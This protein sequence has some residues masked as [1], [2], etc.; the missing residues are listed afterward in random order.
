MA[1]GIPAALADS[2]ALP[3]V[4]GEAGWYFAPEHEDALTATL[5]EL[6]DRSEE[7]VRRVE[8]GRGLAARFRWQSAND[9]L[10][11]ALLRYYVP[12]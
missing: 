4:G 5:R 6:I 10:V 9:R 12:R 11:E 7:R 3:E 1:Q 8:I 2:T